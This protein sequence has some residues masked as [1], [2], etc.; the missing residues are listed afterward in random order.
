[1]AVH[2]RDTQEIDTDI[3]GE[4]AVLHRLNITRDLIDE[5][6]LSVG[7]KILDVG[8]NN[9]T[10]YCRTKG[11]IYTKV[12][13]ETPQ[14][15]GTGGYFGDEDSIKYD[16]RNLPFSDKSY[17]CVIVSFVL[18]HASENTLHLIKSIMGISR[19]Y[20]IIGE[21][22]CSL[23]HPL[24]WQHRCFEHQPGGIFR[25]DEEWRTIF[26]LYNL[27]LEKAIKLRFNRDIEFGN[28]LDNVYR[29]LYQLRI[30]DCG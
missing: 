26:K 9:F 30:N 7:S 22:L 14:R 23:A 8:G 21:D 20:I 18:H 1:M 11:F 19:K 16:G 17:D 10:E 13:L 29:I 15:V 25:S 3:M 24:K 12:D 27:T 4:P 5:M 2:I 28:P 6:D